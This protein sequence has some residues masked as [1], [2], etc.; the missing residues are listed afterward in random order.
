MRCPPSSPVN[1]A[2][3]KDHVTGLGKCCPP[4]W[5]KGMVAVSGGHSQSL[6]K[7]KLVRCS[8]IASAEFNMDCSPNVKKKTNANEKHIPPGVANTQ[9]L[10]HGLDHFQR[11]QSRHSCTMC[12][13][14]SGPNLLDGQSLQVISQ[15]CNGSA[16]YHHVAK[17]LLHCLRHA[18]GKRM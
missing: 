17:E 12:N 4:M 15:C 18:R 1:H 10:L 9:K 8:C 7:H 13:N 16:R 6:T 14:C 5:V 2:H 11:I 3:C